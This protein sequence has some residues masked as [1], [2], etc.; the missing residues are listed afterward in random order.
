[1]DCSVSTAS[2][3]LLERFEF[4]NLRPEEYME[5]LEIEQVCFPP[6]EAFTEPIMRDRAAAAPDLFLAAVDKKTGRI[7]GFLNGLASDEESFRDEFFVNASFHKDDG[8]NV[9]LM[10]LD[11]RPEYR[12]MGLARELM[13]RYIV[14]EKAKGRKGLILTCLDKKVEMYK[15]FGYRYL[16]ESKSVW[17]GEV[18]YEMI[19]EL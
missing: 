6:N 14:R 15:K 3:E 7:A 19:F 10:G 11:V 1:M 4:R 17:G 13:H 8:K 12:G 18:W 5:A 2:E 16:G 9:L